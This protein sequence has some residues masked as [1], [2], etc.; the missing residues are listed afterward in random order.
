MTQ[1]NNYP[2]AINSMM[3]VGLETKLREYLEEKFQEEIQKKIDNL[4]RSFVKDF[5]ASAMN[6]YSVHTNEM[7]TVVKIFFNNEEMF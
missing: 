5:D 6:D 3:L 7:Q 2:E 1:T 4:V